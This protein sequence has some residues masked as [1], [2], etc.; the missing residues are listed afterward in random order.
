MLYVDAFDSDGRREPSQDS[1]NLPCAESYRSM[2]K[3][4][5]SYFIVACSRAAAGKNISLQL[6]IFTRSRNEKPNRKRGAGEEE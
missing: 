5:G 1:T 4:G 3:S 2:L 6:D